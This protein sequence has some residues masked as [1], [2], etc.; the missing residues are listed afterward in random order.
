MLYYM[1]I[2]KRLFQYKLKNISHKKILFIINLIVSIF[3]S[4]MYISINGIRI[5]VGIELCLEVILLT[6]FDHEA[7]IN[8]AFSQSVRNS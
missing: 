5:S 8:F 3:Y 6:A 4:I 2:L 1:I 7:G